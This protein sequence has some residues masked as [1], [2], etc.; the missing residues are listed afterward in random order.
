MSKNILIVGGA[1]YLGSHMTLKLQEKG[2]TPIVLDNLSTGHRHAVQ[3]AELIVGDMGDAACLKY[4]FSKRPIDAVMHF[5]SCIE[6]GESV[7]NPGKYYQNNVANTLTLLRALVQAKI[8]H[9][10]FSSSAAVYGEPRYTPIDETHPLCP[11]NPYGR[12][13]WMV[14]QMLEDFSRGHGL[15]YAALRYFNAA[16]ADPLSRVGEEHPHESHLIP[17]MLAASLGERDALT[18]YGEDYQTPDGTCVRDYVH[19]DDLC[20]AHLLTLQALWEGEGNRIYNLGT[21]RGYSVREVIAMVEKVTGRKVPVVK[22]ERRAGDPAVLVADPG[23]AVRELG[24]K[25][26]YKALEVIVD[27]AWRFLKEKSVKECRVD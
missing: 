24:W 15:Q 4:L 20:E 13:K 18:V 2:F 16:G 21:G 9:F 23:K 6:V 3:H 14:E 25:A 8:K 11:V 19:V 10:I 26:R 7:K 22:G 5:A 17:L 12:S 27:H 1:G